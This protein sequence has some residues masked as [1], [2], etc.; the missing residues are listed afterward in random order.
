M[1]QF[2]LHLLLASEAKRRH[3]I[4]ARRLLIAEG[5]KPRSFDS[6]MVRNRTFKAPLCRGLSR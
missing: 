3:G 1:V 4:V 2:D 6:K 5:A